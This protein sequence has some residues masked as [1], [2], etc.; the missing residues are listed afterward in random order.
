MLLA[1]LP[2]PLK[3]P[4]SILSAATP[5]KKKPN[6]ADA[7]NA[8]MALCVHLEHH[9]RGVDDLRSSS[10]LGR[11]WTGRSPSPEGCGATD[12]PGLPPRRDWI[13]D[14]AAA[15]MKRLAIIVAVVALTLAATSLPFLPGRY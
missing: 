4:A 8:T 9:W 14:M 15:S 12:A 10:R 6:K 7:P 11:W 5:M 1:R 13:V 3:R 2:A